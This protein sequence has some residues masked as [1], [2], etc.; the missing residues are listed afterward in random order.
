MLFYP[1]YKI[2][3]LKISL[4]ENLYDP[5]WL[6]DKFNQLLV[7]DLRYLRQSYS[8]VGKNI[9]SNLMKNFFLEIYSKCP[10]SRGCN[11][12]R[13][14]GQFSIPFLVTHLPLYPVTVKL[15]NRLRSIL[16]FNIFIYQTATYL[17]FYLKRLKGQSL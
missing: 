11:T 12:S 7:E 10:R 2:Y 5:I 1:L 16:S 13:R 9:D 15:L 14:V 3:C 17:Y 6:N 4:Y 8:N